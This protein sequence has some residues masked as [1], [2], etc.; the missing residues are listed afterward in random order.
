MEETK[1]EVT[2]DSII[3][4]FYRQFFDILLLKI[5]CH[6]YKTDKE[7]M[8]VVEESYA[9]VSEELQNSLL[10]QLSITDLA[11]TI[12]I[13]KAISDTFETLKDNILKF[14]QEKTKVAPTPRKKA[15]T[16][17]TNNK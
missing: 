3:M 8:N 9:I 11:A 12:E 13:K 4:N 7:I 5:I 6:V 15:A 1:V 2:I 14:K 16:K 17:K 10:N